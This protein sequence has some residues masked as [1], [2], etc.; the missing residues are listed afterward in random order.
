MALQTIL[1]DNQRKLLAKERDLFNQ[2]VSVL[3]RAEIAPK[4]MERLHQ[5]IVQLDELFLLVV[6]GEFNSGKSAFINALLGQRFLEEGVTPTTHQIHLIRYG[7]EI[8]RE[9]AS[10]TLVTISLPLEF[11]KE[12]NIVDT[13][14]TNAVIR[15]H[16]MITTEFIPR[17][18]VVLFVTSVDR[19]F[20]ESERVFL[21]RIKEWG[22][23]VIIVLNKIDIIDNEEAINKVEA[24]IADNSRQLLGLSPEVFPISAKLALQSKMAAEIKGSKDRIPPSARQTWKASRFEPLEKYILETLDERSR[25]RLKLLSPLGVAEQTLKQYQSAVS[26]RLAL[27]D[28]DFKT[29][30][31][32]ESQ[33]AIYRQ[34]MLRDFGF[35][36]TEIENHL[37]TMEKRG[38][39][40]F[41]ETL[42]LSRIFDLINAERIRGAY[43]REVIADIPHQVEASV[44]ET[45]DWFVN[46]DLYQWQSIVEYLNRQRMP[47]HEEKVIG[48]LGS[49]F[50]YNRHALLESVGKAAQQAV[51]SY[52]KTAE[53]KAIG[54]ATQMAVA[55]A[56]L[57]EAGAI[58]LGTLVAIALSST[59][60]DF[61]G[62]LAASL[63][64]TLGLFV[65][66]AKRKKAKNELQAKISRVRQKLVDSLMSQ[67]EHEL[68]RSIQRIEEAIAPYTRFVRAEGDRLRELQKEMDTLEAALAH[69][70]AQIEQL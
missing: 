36:V 55:Q 6:V 40:F 30:Q 38:L 53:A 2:L 3:A 20:T 44:E 65:I 60:A 34:D 68:N 9:V 50:E 70:K 37:L 23:K 27:L 58:G 69:L 13:P 62:I 17:S 25:I 1:N 35:R 24:Y 19:P 54:E 57:L 31:N 43:E 18:D 21:E 26:Q 59:V 4:D 61:T 14:G 12:T 63:L 11:L 51:A 46:H 32:I 52:D 49:P 64:A 45:I 22:K 41:D 39:N 67:F 42:R 47:E 66:P 56:A 5:S 7:P 28:E 29:I 48:Q 8:Q 33:L 15:Q 16:E 10:P